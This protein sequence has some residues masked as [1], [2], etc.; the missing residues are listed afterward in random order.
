MLSS[1][2][3]NTPEH[4]SPSLPH[5]Y[6]PFASG[7]VQSGLIIPRKPAMGEQQNNTASF[8]QV[9]KDSGLTLTLSHGWLFGGGT[10]LPLAVWR[11]P[12]RV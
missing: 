8:S 10:A 7:S 11:D 12:F 2:G 3:I 9:R 1:L 5:W 6:T 4:F